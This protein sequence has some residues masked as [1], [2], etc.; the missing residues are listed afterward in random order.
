M[1]LKNRNKESAAGNTSYNKTAHKTE[2]YRCMYLITNVEDAAI[3]HEVRKVSAFIKC[4]F[5]FVSTTLF[6]SQ[7]RIISAI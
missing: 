4:S 1:L 2:K 6:P 3:F 7:K 5:Q